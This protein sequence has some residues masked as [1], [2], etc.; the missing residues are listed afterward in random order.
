[1]KELSAA[2]LQESTVLQSSLQPNLETAPTFKKCKI[3]IN[4]NLDN[5][6]RAVA[7]QYFSNFRH[8]SAQ[9]TESIENT[10]AEIKGKVPY[11]KCLE[12]LLSLPMALQGFEEVPELS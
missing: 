4:T 9:T 1:M 10:A 12:R 2:V 3:I 8:K 5:T 7:Q 6:Q 11:R